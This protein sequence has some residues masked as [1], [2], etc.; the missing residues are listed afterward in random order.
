V[1]FWDPAAGAELSCLHTFLGGGGEAA[2]LGGGE[3]A[4][5]GG[6]AF[7]G[8]GALLGGGDLGAASAMSAAG[9]TGGREHQ[10]KGRLVS[11]ARANRDSQATTAVPK[12][13]GRSPKPQGG[14]H[15]ASASHGIKLPLTLKLSKDPAHLPRL[16]GPEGPRAAVLP[17]LGL[18]AVMPR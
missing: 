11:L 17:S 18:F 15:Q 3:A 9:R 16:L 8:G 12:A 10:L 1:A 13:L 14:E 6:G 7:F 2:F 5:L 4:L